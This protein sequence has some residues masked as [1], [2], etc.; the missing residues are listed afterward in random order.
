[1]DYIWRVDDDFPEEMIGEY[2][3]GVSPDRFLFRSGK[4]LAEDIGVPVFR[5]ECRVQDLAVY[6]ELPNSAL[7]PL[8]SR[9]LGEFLVSRC[10]EDIQLLGAIVEC[11]DAPIFGEWSVLVA[12]KM[13]KAIDHELSVY[14]RMVTLDRI[15]S[16]SVLRHVP[17]SLGEFAIA[18]DQEYKGHLILSEA[19]M[20]ELV[21]S[22][23][24][25]GHSTVDDMYTR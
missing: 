17:G 15:L 20:S 25:V 1:M 4:R 9:R 21:S 23:F 10:G 24:R 8:V 16:F 19:L 7:V 3:A 13:V 6:D 5:F 2:R 12:T 22:G 14:S 18:R 11:T